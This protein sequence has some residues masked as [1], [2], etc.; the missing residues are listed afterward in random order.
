MRK[1]ILPVAVVVFGFTGCNQNEEKTSSVF[2]T[3]GFDVYVERGPILGS[4]VTDGDGNRAY[5]IGGGKYRFQNEPK[6]PI[7][8]DGGVIDTNG[9]SLIDENDTELTF[10]MRS[11]KKERVTL[12]GHLI[13]DEEVKNALMEVLD[14]T[15]ESQLLLLPSE[16]EKV[17][18][19]TNV[20][21]GELLDNEGVKPEDLITP[22]LIRSL[23]N[24]IDILVAKYE[25]STDFIQDFREDERAKAMAK[26]KVLG[27]NGK[28]KFE[29]KI[30]GMVDLDS[31]PLSDLTDSMKDTMTYLLNYT[32]MSKNL[33]TTFNSSFSNDFLEKSANGESKH[34]EAVEAL[35]SRYDLN[36]SNSDYDSTY[37]AYES[38]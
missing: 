1:L 12:L 13:E 10:P 15:D 32:K 25:S 4:S 37:T 3:S 38:E 2:S 23:E 20:L 30:H 24:D 7:V 17:A 18:A 9:N 8:A 33:Y 14:I 11:Y 16:S 34:M 35:V 36:V 6:Y 26:G 19:I 29:D 22:S 5:D 21:F 28:K 31:I 27:A